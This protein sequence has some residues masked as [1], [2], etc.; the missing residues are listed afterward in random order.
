MSAKKASA[1][2]LHPLLQM[3]EGGDRRS[4]GRSNEVVALVL[5]EPDLLALL[6][7]GML[8]DDPLLR[9]RCADAAEKVT[10]RH[11]EFLKPYA[12]LLL[13]PL[14]LVEQKEVRW[15]VAPML[16]RLELSAAQRRQVFDI[17]L[18]YLSDTSS[19]VRALT[20]QALADVAMP[21]Q[22]LRESARKHIQELMVT[23]TPAMKARGRTL[24]ARW[25]RL[26]HV[27]HARSVDG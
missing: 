2:S 6:F 21:V 1:R 15:H 8:S 16:A 3:L 19:I 25:G 24:L 4:I 7:T 12:K 10:A 18:G 13:G 26:S 23:G 14:A 5:K 9:M 27:R 20:M 11:P 22:P 17:L